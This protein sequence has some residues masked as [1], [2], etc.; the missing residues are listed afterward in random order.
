MMSEPKRIQKLCP[1][2]FQNITNDEVDFLVKEN[3]SEFASPILKDLL[4]SREDVLY[5][6]FWNGMGSRLDVTQTKRIVITNEMIET[7]NEELMQEQLECIEKNYI[8]QNGGYE[9][10]IKEAGITAIANIMVCNHCHNILPINFWKYDLV[11]IG[12]AGSVASGKTVFLCSLLANGFECLNRT[13]ISVRM[14]HGDP[15]DKNKMQMEQMAEQLV[16]EGICPEPTSKVF[17]Q[18]I[19]LEICYQGEDK[20]HF[21]LLALYDV[22]GEVVRAQA[23]VGQAMFFRY[24]DGII[25]LVDP[26]Q[27]LLEEPIFF[28]SMLDEEKLLEGL[29]LLTREEQIKIQQKSNRNDKEVVFD[30][31]TLHE[32]QSDEKMLYE[33][34]PETILDMIRSGV[35]EGMLSEKYMALTIA[36]CDLLKNHDEIRKIPGYSLLFEREKIENG[37]LNPEHYLIRQRILEQIFEQKIYHIQRNVKEYKKCALFCCSALGCETKQVEIQN[38]EVTKAVKKRDPIRVEE[39]VMWILMKIMQERGWI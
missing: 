7:K 21:L 29:R 8:E 34:K 25:F 5:E 10:V 26:S 20:D 37:F 27:M 35:G 9:V 31:R 32:E 22:A 6:H 4:A 18:P 38:I 30:S 2:C 12:M 19:F 16:R 15:L 3:Q 14:A 11:S 33:R 17:R 13:R 24:M 36:Q 23:G 1:Y 28:K 39:P